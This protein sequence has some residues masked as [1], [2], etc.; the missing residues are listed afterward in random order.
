MNYKTITGRK[1]PCSYSGS[2]GKVSLQMKQKFIVT[3]LFIE[4]FEI[5]AACTNVN[6]TLLMLTTSK[7]F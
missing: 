2:P 4:T 1:W 5:L 3:K 7:R 6:S